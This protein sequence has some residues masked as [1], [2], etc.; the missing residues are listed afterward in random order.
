MICIFRVWQVHTHQFDVLTLNQDRGSND[1]LVDVL[2]VNNSFPPY[3]VQY[4]SNTVFVIVFSSS[5]EDVF[6][7]CFP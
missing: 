2:D 1:T 6:V 5:H 7:T 4:D 3:F